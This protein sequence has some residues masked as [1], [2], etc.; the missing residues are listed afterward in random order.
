MALP[1]SSDDWDMDNE[2]TNLSP[3]AISPHAPHQTQQ[4]QPITPTTPGLNSMNKYE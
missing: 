3:H 2:N 4:P 1:E